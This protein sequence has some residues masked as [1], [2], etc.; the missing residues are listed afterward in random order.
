MQSRLEHME[1]LFMQCCGLVMILGS[2]TVFWTGK[3]IQNQKLFGGKGGHTTLRGHQL[4]GSFDLLIMF[5]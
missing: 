5:L 3:R 1:P 4:N 2:L